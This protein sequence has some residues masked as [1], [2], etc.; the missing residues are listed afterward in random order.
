MFFAGRDAQQPVAVADVFVREAMLLRTEEK[1][2][3]AGR[4]AFAYEGSGLLEAPDG[5]VQLTEANGS[6]SDNERAVRDCFG[7]RFEFFGAG[8]QRRGADGGTRLA[9]SQLVG[10]Y[11]AKMEESEVAH[12]ASGGADVGGIA[13]NDEYEAQACEFGAGRHGW[14]SVTQGRARQKGAKRKRE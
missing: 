7:E 2:Y 13:R 1:G 6:G 11:H 12:G 14:Q 4:E 5:V 8:E 3:G 9:K 10:V